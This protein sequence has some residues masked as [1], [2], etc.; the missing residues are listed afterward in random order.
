MLTNYPLK[1]V[2][3]RADLSGRVSK[4]GVELNAY[5]I[6]FQPRSAIKGQVLADFIAEFA[7]PTSSSKQTELKS[8]LP[9]LE[10][11]D[12]INSEKK[13]RWE[14]K[15]DGASNAKGAGLG[16]VLTDPKGEIIEQAVRL[17]F[18]ALNNE[19]EYEAVMVGL[20]MARAMGVKELSVY[21]DFRLVVNQLNKEYEAKDER[22]T[23]YM[24][25]V[26]ELV[27][28]FTSVEFK[29]FVRDQ[30]RHADGLAALAAALET[31][32]PRTI[33]VEVLQEPSI[34]TEELIL[35]I[36]PSTPSWMDEI[37]AYLQRD[38]LPEDRNQSHQIRAKSA[39]F[40]L[41]PSGSLYK[42]SYTGPY[43]KCVHPDQV[44]DLL[45]ELHEGS[46][47]GHTGGRSLAHRANTQGYWW[48]YMQKDAIRYVKK[49]PKS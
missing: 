28:D 20:G 5:D 43:L 29:R 39:R 48:P 31:D 40:W 42:R 11:E 7:D 21:S 47:G 2:L 24:H 38:E 41:S 13:N 46:C 12:K 9:E 49:C 18:P 10:G 33:N 22:M 27:A 35:D 26:W 17:M 4:W 32:T 8:S 23:A 37:V 44:L 34:G 36:Q 14:L 19:A 45:T 30:N 15:V 6:H 25:K 1:D 16:I 3:R